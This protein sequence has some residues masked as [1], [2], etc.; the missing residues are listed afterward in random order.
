MTKGMIDEVVGA[1]AETAAK[2]VAWG[3]DGVEVHCAHGYL[4]AQFLSA[5]A[6]DREDEYGGSFENRARFIVET[7]R[8]VRA[9][10]PKGYPMGV[11]L[12]PDFTAGGIDSADALRVAQMLE[13]D[14]LLDFVDVSAG[15]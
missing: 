8:A 15:N 9:A 14:A 1:Y 2:C 4:P 12:A 10:V 7:V 11:R 6:N 3:V 13:A 5:N